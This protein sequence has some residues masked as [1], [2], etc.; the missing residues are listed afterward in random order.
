VDYLIQAGS[1]IVP[2]EVKA[3]RTGRLKSLQVFI[4][5]KHAP[6]GLRFND[7]LPSLL[8]S[9][10]SIA[11]KDTVPFKLLSLPL[12][13]VEQASRLVKQMESGPKN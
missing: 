11:G 5:E 9:R 1:R 4:Q 13:L 3:G 2:V 8:E 10:T 12:Y 6:V 7:D